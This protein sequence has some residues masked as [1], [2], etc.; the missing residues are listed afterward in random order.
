MTLH[1]DESSLDRLWPSVLDNMGEAVLVADSSGAILLSNPAALRLFPGSL[2][3]RFCRSER[4]PPLDF[5]PLERCI[6]GEVFDNL[7]VYLPG[8]PTGQWLS[9]AGRPMR[10]AHGVIRGGILVGH[11]ITAR[12]TAE[13]HRGIQYAVARVLAECQT[14]RDG[15]TGILKEL[16]DGLDVEAGVLWI[17][18]DGEGELQSVETWHRPHIEMREL[19]ILTR[20]ARLRL[21]MGLPGQ[22][23]LTGQPSAEI[24][25]PND[26]RFDRLGLASRAGLRAVCAFP[27]Q[28]GPSTVG[29]L[30]LFSRMPLD[31]D[32]DL[33]ALMSALG[34]QLGQV[35]QRQRIEK[36]LRDS[37]TLFASLVESLPQNIFRKDREGRF[38]FANRRFCETVKKPLNEILGRS[39]FELFPFELARKYVQD[40]QAIIETGTPFEAIEEHKTPDGK[41]LFVQVVKTV[42][43]DAAGNVVGVQGIFWDVTEKKIAQEMLAQSERRYRQLTEATLDAVVLTDECDLVILFNPA[44][45]RMFG[46]SAGEMI[47]QPLS[48]VATDEMR[49]FFESERRAA[50]TAE[51]AAMSYIGRTVETKAYRKGGVEFACE[52]SMTALSSGA[53]GGGLQFLAAIR[54]LTERNKMRSTMVQTEKL[55]SIGLLSAGLAH[56]INNPLAFVS[57]NV[58][59]L[60]RDC[61]SLLELVEFVE[62]DTSGLSAE[63]REAWRAKAEAI[64]LEYLRGNLARLLARTRD[65]VERVTRIVQSLRGLARTDAPRRQDVSLCDLIDASLE[66]LRV[67][68]KRSSIE[69]IQDHPQP[70]RVSCVSTQIA[71]VILNL[72][73]NA[74]QAVSTNRRDGGK[75]WIRTRRF[76]CELILEIEDNG[77]GIPDDILPKLFDPFFTTKDVGEGTGLGLSI[78]HQIVIGHGGRIEVEGNPGRGACFRVFLPA[79]EMAKS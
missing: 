26:D 38:V 12:K 44:A 74:F 39:D 22:V 13:R 7:E 53:A 45:E 76:T 10:D 36:A 64:D 1:A 61:L 67:K 11:D 48:I 66:I 32:D 62:R 15:A 65:G 47:G 79:G 33:R 20:K 77:P 19:I 58:A 9:L 57:N 43:I 34:S 51:A 72:L 55:A 14:L 18:H 63:T 75:V 37:E 31:A 68:Y 54:D 29:V 49:L 24:I 8:H 41:Q 73:V 5:D 4:E 56:E 40:D 52:V 46:Y 21:G 30:E 70:P 16:C 17:A 3:G 2:R 25:D 50:Q 6:L 60:E 35:L 78:S 42:V 71:Q 23:W 59:V 69:T 28:Q 27:I